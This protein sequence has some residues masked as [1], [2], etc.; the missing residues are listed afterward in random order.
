M[1]DAL[2]GYN[3]G[4]R[5]Y[6][7]AADSYIKETRQAKQDELT[8]QLVQQ[9]ITQGQRT[10]DYQTQLAAL[11][12]KLSQPKT[13]ES[14][15]WGSPL[16]GASNSGQNFGVDQS[17]GL[18][19]TPA[20]PYTE[21]EKN[22]ARLGLAL[23]HGNYD[24]VKEI[25][26]V[27]DITNKI[28]PNEAMILQSIFKVGEDIY[29]RFKNPE[30]A[31]RAMEM[32]IN[33]D[34]RIPI[35][36]KAEAKNALSGL[37]FG[38]KTIFKPIP[39]E[40][41]GGA[42]VFY[43]DKMHQ[44]TIK[45]PDDNTSYHI[46]KESIGNKQTQ[47]YRVFVD[48]QGNVTKREKVGVPYKNTEGVT[49]VRVSGYSKPNQSTGAYFNPSDKQWHMPTENGDVILTG[50]QVR[51]LSLETKEMTPTETTKV[52]QQTAPKVLDLAQRVKADISTQV[53]NLGPAAG[54]WNEFWTEKV[55]AP[56]PGFKKLQTDV[57]LLSTLLMRMHVGARG[58]VEIMNHF[59]DMF[60]NGKQSAENMNAAVDAVIE[61]AQHTSQSVVNP[62]QP[63]GNNAPSSNYQPFD[64]KL[65][66]NVTAQ[67]I[68]AELNRRKGKK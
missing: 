37:D 58:G 36:K 30:T 49:E 17:L 25:G 64:V 24:A 23:K 27:V 33:A 31:Q 32:A 35:E 63:V 53:D 48:K 45:P 26:N 28:N 8:N 52:M 16:A 29:N 46:E 66:G 50:A 2:T 1:S 67:D 7:G 5:N 41:G 21:A 13:P 65:P 68:V 3:E 44:I 40:M 60:N 4:I 38:P 55:G 42:M 47:D 43:G 6:L 19:Q 39:D 20:V 62:G 10:E 22:Q 14:S 15:Q 9:K 56:N 11:E 57:G 54:R 34:Q 61:Y 59:K 12:D 51:Q 18:Q